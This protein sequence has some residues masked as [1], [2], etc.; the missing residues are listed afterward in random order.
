MNLRIVGANG[1][2][3][4][5]AGMEEGASYEY[6]EEILPKSGGLVTL[7]T[8]EN[9][10]KTTVI[11]L[12]RRVFS[13]TDCTGILVLN[14]KGE[15]LNRISIPIFCTIPLEPS[16]HMPWRSRSPRCC[17]VDRLSK[18]FRYA[19]C[20]PMQAVKVRDELRH[21]RDYL[22]IQELR[23]LK[24]ADIIWD[25]E[26]NYLE[27]PMLRLILQPLVENVFK[28]GFKRGIEEDS[29][30]IIRVWVRGEEFILSVKDNGVGPER[31]YDN[32]RIRSS[33]KDS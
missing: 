21:V 12:C 24:Q 31:E 5:T 10:G 17:I 26:E 14:I 6:Y 33:E 13:G 11:S 3:Y 4:S 23:L 30:L 20:S 32:E 15:E 29:R 19:T 27:Y 25:I 2:W 28:H 22:E 16:T 8:K 7:Q 1:I 9:S 18:M